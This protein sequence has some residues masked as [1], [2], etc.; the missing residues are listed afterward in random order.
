MAH[1]DIK[2]LGSLSKN[3]LIYEQNEAR[4]NAGREIFLN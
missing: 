2:S 1:G 4:K 3:R